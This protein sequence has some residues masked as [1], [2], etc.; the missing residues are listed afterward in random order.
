MAFLNTKLTLN[1]LQI[2]TQYIQLHSRRHLHAPL[3]SLF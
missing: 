3:L 1:V 2:M